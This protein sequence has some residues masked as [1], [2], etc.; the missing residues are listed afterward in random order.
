[1]LN[2]IIAV[3][4]FFILAPV[5]LAVIWIIYKFIIY[6]ELF[7]KPIVNTSPH[8]CYPRGHMPIFGSLLTFN[9]NRNS[10]RGFSYQSM[11]TILNDPMNE[12]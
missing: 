3:I 12:V 10:H 9:R 1:M 8:A 11:D 6:P 4:A 2:T 7:L 5:A